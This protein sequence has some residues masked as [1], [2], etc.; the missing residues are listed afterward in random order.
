M[1]RKKVISEILFENFFFSPRFN[2]GSHK[3]TFTLC[4]YHYKEQHYITTSEIK[5]IQETEESV[6]IETENFI[7][8]LYRQNIKSL[9]DIKQYLNNKNFTSEEFFSNC[10]KNKKPTIKGWELL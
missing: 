1:K 9:Q 5:D 8:A 2:E 7:Y 3:G 6:F 4:V 10:I